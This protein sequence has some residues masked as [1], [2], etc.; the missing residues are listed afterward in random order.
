MN[1]TT[2]G[3]GNRS[4]AAHINSI[5]AIVHD[6]L[7]QGFMPKSES[8]QVYTGDVATTGHQCPFCMG[9]GFKGTFGCPNC[10]G[11]GRV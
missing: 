4:A 2:S 1:T 10:G 11:K 8:T 7:D 5:A 9:S 3:T 6:Y